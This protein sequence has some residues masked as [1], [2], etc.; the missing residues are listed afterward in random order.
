VFVKTAYRVRSRRW[1][2]RWP[3]APFHRDGWIYEE[4]AAG[5]RII[6]DKDDTNVRLLSRNAVD[7]TRRFPELSNAVAKL[8]LDTLVLDGVSRFHLL[9]DA[10]ESIDGAYWHTVCRAS[11][12]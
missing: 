1:R 10:F 7:H 2:R 3:R 12:V 8:W 6:A 11:P 5:R 9:G 4:K